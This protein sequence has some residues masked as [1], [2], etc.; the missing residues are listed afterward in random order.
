VNLVLKGFRTL[1]A[2]PDG[3][4]AVNPT[5]NPGMAKGG[6]GDILTGIIAGLL[7]QYPALP[8]ANVAAGAVYLHGLAGDLAASETDPSS[9][10]AGDLLDAIPKAYQALRKDQA[11]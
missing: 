7:A 3:S 4:V 2:A 11:E 1:I 9:M 10:I 5:G 6:T 8:V